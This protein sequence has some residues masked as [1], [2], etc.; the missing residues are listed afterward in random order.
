[1]GYERRLLEICLGGE[2]SI[3]QFSDILEKGVD[4]DVHDEV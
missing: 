3:T 4:P 2:A 1:M